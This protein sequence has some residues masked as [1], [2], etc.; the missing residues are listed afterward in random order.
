MFIKRNFKEK[1]ILL[2]TQLTVAH[3]CRV[4]L[5]GR[6]AYLVNAGNK[7]KSKIKCAMRVKVIPLGAPSR[8]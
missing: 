2:I 5:H 7:T 4:A 1:N 3:K 8:K 6:R